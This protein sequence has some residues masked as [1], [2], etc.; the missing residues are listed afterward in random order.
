MIK[1]LSLSAAILA[2]AIAGDGRAEPQSVKH[3][4]FIQLCGDPTDYSWMRL[5]GTYDP[6][7]RWTDHIWVCGD[8]L[9][10]GARGPFQAW[11]DDSVKFDGTR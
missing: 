3:G 11:V 2:L 7:W 4:H 6:N 1:P 8:T 5:D 9:V 10:P